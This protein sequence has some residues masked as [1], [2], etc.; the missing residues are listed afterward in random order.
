MIYYIFYLQS[1]HQ[2]AV[3][4]WD[5]EETTQVSEFHGH[6]FGIN[7]VAF[8]PNLKYV[9]SIGTQHDMAVNVWNWR[10]NV[11]VASNKVATKVNIPRNN[12]FLFFIT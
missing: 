6:K 3:R 7:C 1:G 5:V 8:H 4:V 11:K 10:A 2:P 9:V 12:K